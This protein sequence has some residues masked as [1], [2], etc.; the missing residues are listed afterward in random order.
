MNQLDT[1]KLAL[2]KGD[3]PISYLAVFG[4]Y[5]RGEQQQHSDLDLLVRFKRS[6]SLLDMIGIQ[7]EMSQKLGLKVDLVSETA[8]NPRVRPYVMSDLKVIFDEA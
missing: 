8:L 6:L 2:F 4:S 5:A 3:F 7:Q 1:Q